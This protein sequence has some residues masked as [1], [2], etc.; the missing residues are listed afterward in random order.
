[1]CITGGSYGGYV[2]ALA[3]TAGAGYFTHGIAEYSVIDW[4]LYDSHYTE[5]FMDTPAE[6]PDGYK[7]HPS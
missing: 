3:L 2:T 5:R 6:N 7:K 1:M 4:Q